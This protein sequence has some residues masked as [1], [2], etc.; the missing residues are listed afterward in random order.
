MI[1]IYIKRIVNFCRSTSIDISIKFLSSL[2]LRMSV[3]FNADDVYDGTGAQIQRMMSVYSFAR[4]LNLKYIHNP[5]KHVSVHPLDGIENHNDYL[6]FLSRLNSFLNFSDITSNRTI[7]LDEI[8][9]IKIES[10]NLRLLLKF[11]FLSFFEPQCL[12]IQNAF[13]IIDFVRDGYRTS[14]DKLTSENFNLFNNNTFYSNYIV[15]HYRRGHG[16]FAIY[17][18]QKISREVSLKRIQ[19]A[20]L[21]L[22]ISDAASKLM[23]VFTDAPI[24]DI[25][26]EVPFG[27]DVLWKSMPGFRDGKLHLIGMKNEVFDKLSDEPIEI[28][29]GGDPLKAILLM[30]NARYLI[31]GRSSLSYVAALFSQGKVALPNDFWHPS[32]KGWITF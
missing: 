21:K 5:I 17:P 20:L 9:E 28:I 29:R 8:P 15:I 26:F 4:I 14:I 24:N 2:K 32:Q 6:N 13:P 19:N 1:K 7:N 18:G 27:Q 22:E 12:K 16:N 3:E 11:G 25:F 31:V 10:I 23:A 30:S